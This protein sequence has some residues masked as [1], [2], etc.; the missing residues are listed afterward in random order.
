MG[1][2]LKQFVSFIIFFPFSFAWGYSNANFS[3]EP[4]PYEN[5]R[6]LE[7]TGI[8]DDLNIELSNILNFDPL[9]LEDYNNKIQMRI[10]DFFK[11][12]VVINKDIKGVTKQSAKVYVG[13]GL[14][15]VET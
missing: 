7:A 14:F 6:E 4:S 10:Q 13:S 1:F 2:F 12:V 3:G 5:Q 9:N 8:Y 15:L 11:V